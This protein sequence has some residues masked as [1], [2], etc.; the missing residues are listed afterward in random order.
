MKAI[1]KNIVKQ[2]R[3]KLEDVLPLKMPFSIALDPCNLCNFKFGF[4][5]VQSTQEQLPF[6]K[7]F[8]Q[9]D[10]YKKIIDDMK[11]FNGKLRVLRLTGVGEPLL[12]PDYI[13]MIKYAAASNVSEWIETVTNASQLS[14]IYNDQLVNSGINRIRISIEAIDGEGYLN[15]AGVN[16][17]FNKFVDNIRDLY[18]KSRGK[19][20]IYIKT[21][22]AAV[23]TEKKKEI[24]Y[25]LFGDIC[26]AI[27]IDTVIPLWSDYAEIT[28][29]FDIH[30]KGMHGQELKNVKI[31]PYSFYNLIINSD[32]EVTVCCADWK[33]KL[34]VG[35]LKEQSLYQIWN[36]EKL[37]KF[38]IDMLQGNKNEYE[39]CRKCLLPIYDCN[40]DIDD[41][42]DQILGRIIR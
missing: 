31:C 23:N 19:C 17:D 32:G 38:W 26:D 21:V 22:D 2:N 8:M 5:A 37:R 15:I 39:M 30:N 11:E 34:V 35:D 18:Q 16:I 20:E 25:D 42:A 10:L 41:Y 4:C 3:E 13:D 6:R 28:E 14:P 12:N 33:R 40:D 1:N 24:F 7:Q 27:F 36:G 9:L 29:K